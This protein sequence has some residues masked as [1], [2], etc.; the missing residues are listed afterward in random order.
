MSIEISTTASGEE[1]GAISGASPQPAMDQVIQLDST[2]P[3]LG[4]STPASPAE[5][6]ADDMID[7]DVENLD[8][9]DSELDAAFAIGGPSTGPATPRPEDTL[10]G[11]TFADDDDEPAIDEDLPVIK[12][13]DVEDLLVELIEE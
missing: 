5:L 6:S 8:E 9:L 11:A 12:D 13:E 3:P 2:L 4:D 10:A 1:A 7:P